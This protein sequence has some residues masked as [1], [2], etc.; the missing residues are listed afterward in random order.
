LNVSTF[1]EHIAIDAPR[2]TVWETLSDIGTI[3]DWNPGLIGSHRTN[4]VDGVG[5]TRRCDLCTKHSLTEQ[6]VHH[7]APVAITFRITHTT[8]PFRTADIAFELTDIND[9]SGTGVAVTPTYT[10]KSRPLGRL[11]DA[12]AVRRSYRSGMRELLAGLKTHIEQR[13]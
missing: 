2:H 1:T 8:L 10:L 7:R 6:V 9:R 3:A 11:I 12:I 5:G 4:D 13:Q